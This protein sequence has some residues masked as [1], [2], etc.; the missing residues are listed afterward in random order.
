[1]YMQMTVRV[2]PDDFHIGGTRL[3]HFQQGPE[4]QLDGSVTIKGVIVVLLQKLAH[5]SLSFYQWRWL[6]IRSESQRVRSGKVFGFLSE[7]APMI[8]VQ[9]PN[10]RTPPFCVYFC[11]IPAMKRAMYSTDAGSSTVSLCDW[12]STRALLINT[13]ASAVRPIVCRDKDQL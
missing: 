2:H 1:M 12:H 7:S 8:S 11:W 10:G 6:S 4:C 5:S 3:D 13:R 9:S